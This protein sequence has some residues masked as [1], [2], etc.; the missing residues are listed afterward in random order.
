MFEFFRYIPLTMAMKKWK[1]QR[2]GSHTKTFFKCTKCWLGLNF[3]FDILF[4]KLV[5]VPVPRYGVLCLFRAI[6]CTYDVY[7]DK[8]YLSTRDDFFSGARTHTHV[9]HW[10]Y[11][12][13]KSSVVTTKYDIILW[14]ILVGSW[15]W[16][17]V[18][19]VVGGRDEAGRVRKLLYIFS[20]NASGNYVLWNSS[21]KFLNFLEPKTSNFFSSKIITR[22]PEVRQ[23]KG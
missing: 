23:R 11:S 9:W 3:V 21:L 19:R 4:R 8:V 18:G 22:L 12:H 15:K 5:L 10:N 20:T 6:V 1:R 7:F 2:D 17:W 16:R 13:S 14:N